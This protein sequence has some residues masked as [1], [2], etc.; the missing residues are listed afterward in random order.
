MGKKPFHEWE[1]KHGLL[2]NNNINGFQYWNYM[3]RDMSMSFTDEFTKVEPAF[4]RN[5][6]GYGVHGF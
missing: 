5:M 2:N 3:R 6:K 1:E 4:Y